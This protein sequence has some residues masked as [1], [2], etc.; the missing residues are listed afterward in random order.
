MKNA[1]EINLVD[2]F[3]FTFRGKN[4][5]FVKPYIMLTKSPIEGTWIV[6]NSVICVF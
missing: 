6:A 3:F 4:I 2:F 5:G 1:C